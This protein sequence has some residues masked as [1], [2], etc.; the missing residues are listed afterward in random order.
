MKHTI[1]VPTTVREIG[2]L[3]EQLDMGFTEILDFFAESCGPNWWNHDHEDFTVEFFERSEYVAQELGHT[4]PEPPSGYDLADGCS[5]HYV[6]DEYA[7]RGW[8][9]TPAWNATTNRH[10]I[11]LWLADHEE[12]RYADLAPEDAYDLA[13]DLIIAARAVTAESK[14]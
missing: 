6:G 10:S 13:A 8:I 4:T 11:E 7:K 14:A 3:A 12:P 1:K 2:D 9:I 5:D